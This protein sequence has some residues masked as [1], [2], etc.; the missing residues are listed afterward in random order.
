MTKNTSQYSEPDNI[1]ALIR[2]RLAE[3]IE[4]RSKIL[5][6][7]E[8]INQICEIADLMI[9]LYKKGKK[10]ILFGN[11]G[12]AAD[13]QHIATELLGRYYADRK[14]LPAEALTVNTSLLTAIGNDY[15]FD[16]IFARQIE[17]LG[18]AG[19]IAIGISTSGNSINV[20]EGLR[21]AKSK[22]L[23]TVGLTGVDG[24]KLRNAV[25]YCVCVPSNDTPRIQEAHIL[26]G[27]ILCELV[28]QAFFGEESVQC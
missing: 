20:I 13:A 7:D 6:N 11:G 28:E 23:F 15:A 5:Q 27:H 9:D 25:D 12:S 21:M 16:Q 1:K 4:V 3:S 19:D 8:I 2:G 10:V 17:G 24:G 14:P 18:N 26:I 22:G